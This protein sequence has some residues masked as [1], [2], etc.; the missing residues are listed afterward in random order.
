L[1][2]LRNELSFKDY[3]S[4]FYRHYLFCLFFR[5]FPAFVSGHQTKQ[6]PYRVLGDSVTIMEMLQETGMDE[7]P[8]VFAKQGL[9]TAKDGGAATWI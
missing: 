4:L 3:C 5:T 8:R 1:E 7:V 9:A 6:V 2:F